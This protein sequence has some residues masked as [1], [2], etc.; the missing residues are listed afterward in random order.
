M[1]E[2]SGRKNYNDL[3]GSAGFCLISD[4]LQ[5]IVCWLSDLRD[6]QSV[7]AQDFKWTLMLD[8]ICYWLWL[9]VVVVGLFLFLLDLSNLHSSFTFIRYI[10]VLLAYVHMHGLCLSKSEEAIGSPRTVVT[11]G[12]V[13]P[14]G[15]WEMGLDPLKEK[16]LVPLKEQEVLNQR[17]VS[18][19]LSFCFMTTMKVT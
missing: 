6:T 7:T 18:S 12:C 8:C 17:A 15:C 10:H 3:L 19:G 1:Q 5:Y 4:C 14:C 9:V 13:S 16:N 11:D 2:G